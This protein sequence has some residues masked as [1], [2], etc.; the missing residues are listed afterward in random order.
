[1]LRPKGLAYQD[2]EASYTNDRYWPELLSSDLLPPEMAHRLVEAQLTAAGQFCG[3]T[4]FGNHLDDWPLADYLYGLWSMG[5]KNDFL[6][7][8]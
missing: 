2:D 5:R 3:M 1:M 8:L 7:S 4:R 6:L